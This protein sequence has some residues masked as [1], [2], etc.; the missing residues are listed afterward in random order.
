MRSNCLIWAL[1]TYAVRL[2][3]WVRCGMPKGGEPYLVIRPSRFRPRWVPHFLVGELDRE[4]G[5]MDLDSYKPIAGK[6]VSGWLVW[7]RLLFRGRVERG[8]LARPSELPQDVS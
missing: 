5:V 1:W 7:L 2:R 4:S 8:D 3:A 6:D